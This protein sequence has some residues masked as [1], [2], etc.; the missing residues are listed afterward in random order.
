[1]L[2]TLKVILATV[3]ATCAA[4]LAISGGL[5]ATR[6]PGEQLSGVPSMSRP[7]VRG[8]IVE[9]TEWQSSRL[10]TCGAPTSCSAC[11]TCQRPRR[12]PRGRI[13]R[14]RRA[15]ARGRAC[16]RRARPG[17]PSRPAPAAPPPA[18]EPAAVVT[19]PNAPPAAPPASTT[20]ANAPA[21]ASRGGA[22]RAATAA[23][24]QPVQP[25][26]ARSRRI[27]GAPGGDGRAGS[28]ARRRERRHAGRGDPVRQRGNGR[29][30]GNG[31][32][33]RRQS[34]PSRQAPCGHA[35]VSPAPACAYRQDGLPGRGAEDAGAS[36][37]APPTRLDWTAGRI[38][39]NAGSRAAR[40][41]ARSHAEEPLRVA[42]RDLGLVLVAQRHAFHPRAGQLGDEWQKWQRRPLTRKPQWPAF[43]PRPIPHFQPGRLQDGGG[44]KA[45]T[46]SSVLRRMATAPQG[47]GSVGRPDHEGV[48]SDDDRRRLPGCVEAAPRQL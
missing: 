44:V 35:P 8:A 24:T 32:S 3:I 10:P 23:I 39:A 18:S 9:E 41:R 6:D 46:S 34:A 29:R 25:P 17:R 21:A 12:A 37:R 31:K 20:V 28:G 22:R 19:S 30:Q 5:I 13:C 2:P 40:R 27:A 42:A 43:P 38:H 45:R 16:A 48:D 33:G 4:V 7:L 15:G 11:V 14:A 26:P 1:M 47:G 36:Q